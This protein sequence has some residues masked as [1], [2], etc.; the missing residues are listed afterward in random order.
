LIQAFPGPNFNFSTFLGALTLARSS[1]F[2]GAVLAFLGIFAPGLLFALGFQGLWQ[3][4]RRF[5]A[6][7]AL[8]RG[9]NAVA[10]GLVFTAVWR[11]WQIGYLSPG[12]PNGNSL[13]DEPFWMVVSVAAF[14]ASAWFKTPPVVAILSGGVL[15][16]CWYGITQT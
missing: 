16:L 8:L 4:I 15:G 2:L 9:I 1:S 14:S 5:A 7:N 3:A 13:G 11:L 6:V 10:V 12:Q